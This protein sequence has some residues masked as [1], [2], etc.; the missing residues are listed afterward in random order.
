MSSSI[1][2]Q[3]K[4]IVY[5]MMENRSLD[6]LLG[7]LYED[8]KPSQVFPKDGP[9][10]FDGLHGKTLELPDRYGKLHLVTKLADEDLKKWGHVPRYNPYEMFRKKFNNDPRPPYSTWHGVMNQLY[11]DAKMIEGLPD[12]KQVDPGMRGFLQDYQFC[13][14]DGQ[15]I[16]AC[17][18][19]HQVPVLSG[20]ARSYAVSDRWFSS[21]PSQTNPNRA[22]SLCG[23]SMGRESNLCFTANEQFDSP[24]FI[25]W[26][27]KAGKSVG[28]FFEDV[29]LRG[30]CY[31]EWTFPRVSECSVLERG[32][33]AGFCEKAS[34]GRLPDFSYLEP[35]WSGLVDGTDYHPP[36]PV[37]PAEA[38]LYRVYRALRSS[39]HWEE[40]LFI[41]TF[42]EHGGCYDHVA[43]PRGVI[44]PDSLEGEDGFKFDMFGVRVPTLLVSPFVE[45]GTVF[46]SG[47]AM[48]FD[49]TSIAKT[50]L[51]WAG[52]DLVDVS[53]SLGARMP[54]AP[55]FDDVLKD[56]MVNDLDLSWE[57]RSPLRPASAANVHP[58]DD[59]AEL[60]ALFRTV[61]AGIREALSILETREELVQGLKAYQ[62]GEDAFNE[63]IGRRLRELAGAGGNQMR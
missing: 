6:S 54:A 18:Q 26:L 29:W 7:W 4:K 38:C 42:D 48:D 12:Y 31:T 34:A 1:L 37:E 25:N 61:P 15:G 32:S 33:L 60:S 58:N 5:L 10:E 62:S 57:V 49:H 27:S 13:W 45:S 44:R 14:D 20:L 51:L 46:R 35:A 16:L 53:D 43:P 2:P 3:I 36:S 63:L 47:E 17:Y 55:T 8:S 11:G 59:R 24:T 22:F 30:K 19:P 52:V 56:S 40:T 41:V 21:V 50:L 9:P 39:P 28:L 23:T